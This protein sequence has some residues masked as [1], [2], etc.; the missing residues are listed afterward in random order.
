M[1]YYYAVDIGGTF[2]KG[3]I[4]DSQNK[5]LHKDSVPTA[6]EVDN[7]YLVGRILKLVQKL[8]KASG[9]SLEKSSGLGI[10]SPGIIDGKD[11]IVCFSGNLKLKNYP[12]FEKLRQYTAVPIKLANDADVATLA[13]LVAGNGNPYKNFVMLTLGSGIGGGI[14][15]NGKL[16]SE[17]S[18][19]CGEL[20]HMKISS[21]GIKCSCGEENCFEALA[22]TKALA[23][24]TK[25]AML[26]DKNSQM[27]Q[28]YTA[29]T[30]NGKTVFEFM[31]SDKTARKVFEKYIENLGNG[32]VNL[33]NIFCPEA[34]LVGGAISAQGEKLIKPLTDYVNNH[35][36]LR[37]INYNVNIVVAK[38]FGDA[39]LIG[40]KC[41]FGSKSN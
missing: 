31:D 26:A 37:H 29:E 22:S 5:I 24:Q 41:L 32:I 15:V 3:G 19:M 1:K 34:I 16:L 39:G 38:H 12:L 18:P 27:W 8:E 28:S 9:L 14:V 17:F 23:E 2:I 40:G 10:G 6:P 4:V 25:Q 7:D 33:V 36:Y 21:T 11:G 20:G 13:E 35:N 30:A